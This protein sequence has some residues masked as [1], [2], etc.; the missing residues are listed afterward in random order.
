MSLGDNDQRQR[1]RGDSAKRAVPRVTTGPVPL[2]CRTSCKPFYPGDF[3][4]T[5]HGQEHT[6]GFKGL[7]L[8]AEKRQPPRFISRRFEAH[9]NAREKCEPP[10]LAAQAGACVRSALH[11]ARIQGD[12][13]LGSLLRIPVPSGA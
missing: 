8:F 10:S 13:G 4:H 11:V 2:L 12:E 3:R 6:L 1:L 5:L 7:C 9:L